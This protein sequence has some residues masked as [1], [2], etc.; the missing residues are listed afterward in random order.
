MAKYHVLCSQRILNVLSDFRQRE[1]EIS[2]EVCYLERLVAIGA[3][4]ELLSKS[5]LNNWKHLC[6]A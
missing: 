1:N 4:L 5:K 6:S 2:I 3:E